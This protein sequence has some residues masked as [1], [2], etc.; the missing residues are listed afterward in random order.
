MEKES[1]RKRKGNLHVIVGASDTKNTC[2]V[3]AQVGPVLR[4]LPPQIQNVGPPGAEVWG[5]AG[6]VRLAH[7]AVRTGISWSHVT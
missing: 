1:N 7:P 3:P 6:S 4:V 2:C 5:C